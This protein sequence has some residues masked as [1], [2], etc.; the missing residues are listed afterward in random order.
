DSVSKGGCQLCGSYNSY[1]SSCARG[2]YVDYRSF[3]KYEC[4]IA[5]DAIKYGMKI[6]VLYNSGSVNRNLC[7]EVVRYK[8][9]HKQMW[10]QG[11]DGINYWDYRGIA[12]A[13]GG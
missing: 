1:T 8:G 13:V 10:V 9:I 2:Y 4:D 6:V 12:E 7:P 5:V 3:I 11:S